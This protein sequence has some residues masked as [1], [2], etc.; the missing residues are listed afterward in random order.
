MKSDTGALRNR[1][2]CHS[3]SSFV[4]SITPREEI[5]RSS[6]VY[7][8]RDRVPAWSILPPVTSNAVFSRDSLVRYGTTGASRINQCRRIDM[9]LTI[10]NSQTKL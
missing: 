8:L 9:A 5:S 6:I 4:L 2:Y 3:K 7:Y 1:G 10:H